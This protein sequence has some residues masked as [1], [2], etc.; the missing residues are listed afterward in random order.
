MPATAHTPTQRGFTLIELLV[1]V[2]ILGIVLGVTLP[3]VASQGGRGLAQDAADAAALLSS[4]AGRR[5]VADR[6]LR[7][8]VETASIAVLRRVADD[9]GRTV[10]REDPF[11]PPVSLSASHVVGVRVDGGAERAPPQTIELAGVGAAIDLELAGGGERQTISLPAG[12]LRATV[13]ERPAAAGAAVDL[14]AAGM[15]STPW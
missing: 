8:R 5:A 15:E 1:T 13:G 14:D 12:A 2:A 6:P 4:A 7:L 11:I 10:W 9:R 3:R